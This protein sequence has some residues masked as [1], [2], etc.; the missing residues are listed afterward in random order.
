MQN[1]NKEEEE[2]KVGGCSLILRSSFAQ[3]LCMGGVRR[4]GRLGE[5]IIVK[6][7]II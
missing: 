7:I 5:T 6:L 4:L 3:G 1:F 2:R